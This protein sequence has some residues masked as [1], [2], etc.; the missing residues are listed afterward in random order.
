MLVAVRNQMLR[1]LFGPFIVSADNTGQ[2]I[3]VDWAVKD[4]DRYRN[5]AEGLN[6]LLVTG[7]CGRKQDAVNLV[8]RQCVE[9]FQID[10]RVSV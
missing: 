3:T 5:A 1:R 10:E 7:S 2:G 4:D 9:T 8:L 6:Q